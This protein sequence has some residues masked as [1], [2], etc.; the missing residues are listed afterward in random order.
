MCDGNCAN[1]REQCPAS[2]LLRIAEKENP[3]KGEVPM[4][5]AVGGCHAGPDEKIARL[6]E[7]GQFIVERNNTCKAFG[8]AA[9]A[10]AIIALFIAWTALHDC[11]NFKVSLAADRVELRQEMRALA[12][13]VDEAKAE[14]ARGHVCPQR[15]KRGQ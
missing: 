13:S 12:D 9:F 10:L 3:K 14:A 4:S 6:D 5:E 1:C 7:R 11:H 15:A 2:K 8:I